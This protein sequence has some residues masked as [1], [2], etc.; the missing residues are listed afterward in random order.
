MARHGKINFSLNIVLC[1][2]FLLLLILRCNIDI[3]KIMKKND[4]YFHLLYICL[5]F[6]TI[7]SSNKNNLLNLLQTT[8]PFQWYIIKQKEDNRIIFK[9]NTQ[10]INNESWSTLL[11]NFIIEYYRINSKN[12]EDVYIEFNTIKIIE[13]VQG[14]IKEN[15]LSEFGSFNN[16]KELYNILKDIKQNKNGPLDYYV[17]LDCCRILSNLHK[18]YFS[19]VLLSTE[20]NNNS[21]V[22][23][24][25]DEAVMR[26][27]LLNNNIENFE[28]NNALWQKIDKE[29]HILE[30]N[31]IGK[32][33]K[34]AILH[35]QNKLQKI[36]KIYHDTLSNM[37]KDNVKNDELLKKLDTILFEKN[38]ILKHLQRKA[39]FAL[40]DYSY[41][42]VTKNGSEKQGI[43]GISREKASEVEMR[44]KNVKNSISD[45]E[46]KKKIAMNEGADILVKNQEVKNRQD[47]ILKNIRDLIQNLE[48]LQVLLLLS[49]SLDSSKKSHAGDHYFIGFQENMQ[50]NWLSE[51]SII[52]IKYNDVFHLI[53][54]IN[55]NILLI[56]NHK[57]L[58]IETKNIIKNIVD[59]VELFRLIEP[60]ENIV[61]TKDENE[62]NILFYNLFISNV[63][64]KEK[65]KSIKR[66]ISNN[67]QLL[68]LKNVKNIKTENS[69]FP[70][71]HLLNQYSA[72]QAVKNSH[73]I[74]NFVDRINSYVSVSIVLQMLNPE[75]IVEDTYIGQLYNIIQ[76]NH[77]IS[78][79]IKKDTGVQKI[80]KLFQ[81]NTASGK[82]SFLQWLKKWIV[83]KTTFNQLVKKDEETNNLQKKSNSDDNNDNKSEIST[84]ASEDLEKDINNNLL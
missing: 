49:D 44:I 58:D 61:N 60:I 75:Q 59:I 43:S 16:I 11:N 19:T 71:L 35:F 42:F 12:K 73:S 80:G 28:K 48:Q 15:I 36:E 30:Q 34:I 50:K 3:I 9:I 63:V 62:S 4:F 83:K 41:D 69:F 2:G 74:D 46:S 67:N 56:P 45:Y 25:G 53:R 7:F 29:I 13:M 72:H 68:W 31:N 54:K 55:D 40:S 33:L 81:N 24:L 65:L 27:L 52:N 84:N 32:F 79:E 26:G 38:D 76:E 23:F 51:R 10:L 18:K 37:Q 39:K 1:K 5:F 20:N 66:I 21:I 77:S 22:D 57:L 17:V 70:F 6:Y 64:K 82:E 78:K 47:K 8:Q 14:F